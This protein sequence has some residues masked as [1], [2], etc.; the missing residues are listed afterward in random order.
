MEKWDPSRL[1]ED[2]SLDLVVAALMAQASHVEA[3]TSEQEERE[4][5]IGSLINVV[6]RPKKVAQSLH[7]YRLAAEAI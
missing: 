3:G 6:R 1:T 4:M 7:R 2:E 5:L